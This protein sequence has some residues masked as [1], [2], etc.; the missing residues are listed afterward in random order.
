MGSDLMVR[1]ADRDDHP[2]F[3]EGQVWRYDARTHEEGSV[4]V[5]AKIDEWPDEGTVY[6]CQVTGLL[7]CRPDGR[8]LST[9]EHIPVSRSSLEASVVGLETGSAEP[10]NVEEG[11]SIWKAA[12]SRGEA[13][14][15]AI[16]IKDIVA[17][18]E[19]SAMN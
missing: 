1:N 6:H 16:P 19:A 9:L 17:S 12:F 18:V 11:Y 4:L 5:I 3:A 14:V 10:P 15:Y 7:V 13:G 2:P 8:V